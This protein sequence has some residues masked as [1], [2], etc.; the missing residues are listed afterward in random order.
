MKGRR[1][2]W[3]FGTDHAVIATEAKVVQ[4]QRRRNEQ[5]GA[6]KGGV[7]G[8]LLGV[9]TKYGS[10]IVSS[11]SGSGPRSTTTTRFTMDEGF[12]K[13]VRHVFTRL[14]EKGLVY[15]DH[16]M[17]NWDPGT[18]SAISEL[19]VEQRQVED[20]LYSVD[21]PLASGS[22]SVAIAT[23]RPETMLADPPSPCTRPMSA[24]RA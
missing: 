20:T 17:V 18:R 3:I 14:Y 4:A 11:S 13:A 1:A 21:Y 16:C 24:T 23:V 7:R 2:K 10:T 19:E 8:V 6:R 15:R 22:G 5:G 12:A 9:A